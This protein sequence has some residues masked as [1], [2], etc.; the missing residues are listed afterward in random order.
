MS[1]AKRLTT[2][3]AAAL[4]LLIAVGGTATAAGLNVLGLVGINT[5]QTGL[6]NL[7][8]T[9][10]P[11]NDPIIAL[12]V[13]ILP[14]TG[15]ILFGQSNSKAGQA[16]IAADRMVPG[17]VRSG[18]VTIR[19]TG[20]LGGSFTLKGENRSDVPGEGGGVLSGRLKVKITE[21]KSSGAPTVVYN[22][23][24]KDLNSV[25]LGNYAGGEQRVYTFQ[26]TF[27]PGTGDNAYQGARSA[28]DLRWVATSL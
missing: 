20:T 8:N 23:L 14:G 3:V 22:G 1:N 7:N 9:N 15:N 5:G 17:D 4:A 24:L 18:A 21:Q 13:V 27:P 28:V 26:V 19:S 11:A 6:I 10:I 2:A 25:A 12:D 16:V